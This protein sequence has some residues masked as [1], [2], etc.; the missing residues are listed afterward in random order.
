LPADELAE[1]SRTLAR[2]AAE[3]ATAVREFA[4][5]PHISDEIIGFHAQQAIEKWLKAII[6]GRGETFDHTHDLRRL[7]V[8]VAHDP[9][10]SPLTQTPPS[11]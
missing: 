1:A 9:N 8:L 7:M 4:A 3:D 11:R 6:A 5:H 10:S 2:K